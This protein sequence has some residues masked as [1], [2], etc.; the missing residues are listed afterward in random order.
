MRYP[1]RRHRRW[2]GT[3][4]IAPARLEA[5]EA[6]PSPASSETL[7]SAGAAGEPETPLTYGQ[8]ARLALGQS[9]HA[10]AEGREAQMDAC[11]RGHGWL[12]GS[13]ALRRME[14]KVGH[15][16]GLTRACFEQVQHGRERSI[17]CVRSS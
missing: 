17:P 14:L 7:V 8:P 13:L 9:S 5:R 4:V 16:N 3:G 1:Q 12:Y 10:A 11:L 6:Q 2:I 15:P